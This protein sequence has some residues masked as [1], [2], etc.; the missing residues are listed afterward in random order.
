MLEYVCYWKIQWKKL[1]NKSWHS[2]KRFGSKFDGSLE[3]DDKK[4][5]P[6]EKIVGYIID[7]LNN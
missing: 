4:Q 2:R 6:I 7:F 1:N 5:T 3:I